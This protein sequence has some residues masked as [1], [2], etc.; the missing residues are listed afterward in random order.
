MDKDFV[1]RYIQLYEEHFSS[2]LYDP[3]YLMRGRLLISDNAADFDIM[4]RLYEPAPGDE[5]KNEISEAVLKR[6]LVNH[7]TKLIIVNKNNK[8]KLK[9]IKDHF[10]ALNTWHYNTNKDFVYCKFLQDK[11]WLIILNNINGTTEKK[12]K[13]LVIEEED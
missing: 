1:N 3:Q 11:T 5:N 9:L 6:T 8:E 4:G 12:M 7:G 10:S 13:S 2:W